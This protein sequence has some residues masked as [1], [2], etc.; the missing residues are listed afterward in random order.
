MPGSGCTGCSVSDKNAHRNDAL[1][2]N[3]I[4]F[5]KTETSVTIPD[6]VTVIGSSAFGWCE[7]LASASIPATVKSIGMNAFKGCPV[8]FRCI[9]GSYA[10]YWGR[11]YSFKVDRLIADVFKLPAELTQ[12]AKDACRAAAA[13]SY[14]VPW[15]VTEIGAS[16]FAYLKFSG[17]QIHLP[18]TV[19]SIAGSAFSGSTVTVYCK[20]GSYA[21][22]WCKDHGIPVENED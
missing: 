11:S 6:R 22:T 17:A 7:R 12:L 15:G 21:D 4:C 8:V 19:T 9:A 2:R 14:V 1:N 18:A 5:S 13:E 10:D 16:A 3:S 20:E